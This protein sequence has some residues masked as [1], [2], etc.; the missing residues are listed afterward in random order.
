[1]KVRQHFPNIVEID[2]PAS[3]KRSR[4]RKHFVRHSGILPDG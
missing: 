1:V 2:V 3:G 4:Y